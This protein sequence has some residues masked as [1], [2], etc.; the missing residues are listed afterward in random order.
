VSSGYCTA[1]G[2]WRQPAM[3]MGTGCPPRLRC[4]AI[5]VWVVFCCYVAATKH[6]PHPIFGGCYPHCPGGKQVTVHIW[7]GSPWEHRRLACFGAGKMP[8]LPGSGP[9][10]VNSYQEMHAG[11]CQTIRVGGMFFSA[12]PKKHTP[13]CNGERVGTWF[14]CTPAGVPR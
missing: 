12:T 11:A 8:A 4:R 10:F 13:H 5:S 6:H 9:V 14:P 3:I 1:F 7:G 2:L